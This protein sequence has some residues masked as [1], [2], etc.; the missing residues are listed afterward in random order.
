MNPDLG[1]GKMANKYLNSPTENTKFRRTLT[2]SKKT[3]GFAIA[4][5]AVV[6]LGGMFFKSICD[7]GSGLRDNNLGGNQGRPGNGPRPQQGRR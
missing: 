4:G 7:F 2:Y 3:T 6:I 1:I 5:F